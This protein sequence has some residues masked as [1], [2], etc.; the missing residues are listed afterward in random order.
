M[1]QER[2]YKV[3][4][5]DDDAKHLLLL[6]EHLNKHLHYN[7]DITTFDNG[8]DALKALDQ[9]P[10][11]IILDYYFDGEGDDAMDGVSVLRKIRNE[12]PDIAVV[13]MSHQDSIEVAVTCFDYGA[14]DYVIKNE[15]AYARA[16]LV[17]RNIIH[18]INKEELA[19]RFKES[20]TTAYR[21]LGAFIFLL[22]A[23]IVYLLVFDN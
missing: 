2:S 6:K 17:V 19:T 15:T 8:A 11:L 3:F 18:E 22:I 9:N 12:R 10:D 5:V 20:T 14:K 4:L 7:L 16:Q 21:L 13:M 23:A 1:A